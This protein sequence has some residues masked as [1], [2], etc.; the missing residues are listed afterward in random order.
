MKLEIIKNENGD[1]RGY[2][3][4]PETEEEAYALNFIRNIEFGHNGFK[5]DGRE[6][7]KNFPEHAGDLKWIVKP[8]NCK[9]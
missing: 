5:Y 6:T 1:Y 4:I 3:L 9:P 8:I 7:N 2:K